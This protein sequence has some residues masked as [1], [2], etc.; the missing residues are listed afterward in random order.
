MVSQFDYFKW[1]LETKAMTTF[2]ER[3]AKF[4]ADWEINNCIRPRT[5]SPSHKKLNEWGSYSDNPETRKRK[6]G[7][8]QEPIKI[9]DCDLM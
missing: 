8:C 2:L 6:L 9:D 5:N 4:D 1:Y 3:L 7:S